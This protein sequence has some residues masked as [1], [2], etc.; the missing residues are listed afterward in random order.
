MLNSNHDLFETIFSKC[1]LPIGVLLNDAEKEQIMD[2]INIVEYNRKD[3]ILKQNSRTSHILYLSTGLVKISRE[4]RRSKSLILKLQS[5]GDF[6]GISSILGGE[7]YDFTVSAVDNCTAAYIDVNTF[8]TIMEKNGL[9]SIEIARQI[10]RNTLFNVNRLSGLLYKQL[11]GR[12]ADLILYFS[13]NIYHSN[14]YKFPLTRQELAEL[15]GTTKE[16]L[17]RT[18]SEFNHDRII[19]MDRSSVRIISYD[20]LRTL[21]R[22]G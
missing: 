8:T 12:I 16:S 4:L 14:S 19:E 5:S 22:L 17:I 1:S 11:P 20:V 9:F 15:C 13:E 21:S 7:S 10:S 3:I 2:N 18:L 6:V